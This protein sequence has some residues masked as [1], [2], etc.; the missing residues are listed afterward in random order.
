MQDHSHKLL[1]LGVTGLMCVA[2]LYGSQTGPEMFGGQSETFTGPSPV[3]PQGSHQELVTA[4][5]HTPQALD[6]CA[7]A[8]T[9]LLRA[10]RGRV[11]LAKSELGACVQANG[12][13][14]SS[15]GTFKA[16][17]ALPHS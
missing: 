1:F 2:A 9:S 13:R 11:G 16:T 14:T 7:M 5:F 3:L 15:I 6:K 8:P 12:S 10:E 17:A 4:A